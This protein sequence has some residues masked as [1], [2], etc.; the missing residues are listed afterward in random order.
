MHLNVFFLWI[1]RSEKERRLC[2][3]YQKIDGVRYVIKME[4]DKCVK[5]RDSSTQVVKR[6]GGF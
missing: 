1:S 3:V 5:L 4:N 2:V 6:N